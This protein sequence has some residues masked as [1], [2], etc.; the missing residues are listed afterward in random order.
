MMDLINT[1]CDSCDRL[2]RRLSNTDIELSDLKKQIDILRA[3]LEEIYLISQ[4][5]KYEKGPRIE[6]V[7]NSTLDKAKGGE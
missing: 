5:H 3:G 6:K 7:Y 1:S 2:H 4:D